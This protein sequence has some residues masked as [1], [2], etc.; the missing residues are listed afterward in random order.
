MGDIVNPY[1]GAKTS[2]FI[3]LSSQ[4]KKNSTFSIYMGKNCVVVIPLTSQFKSI[5]LNAISRSKGLSANI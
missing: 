1:S 3:L 2:V 5:I 4:P